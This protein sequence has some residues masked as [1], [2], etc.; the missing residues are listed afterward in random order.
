VGSTIIAGAAGG[1]GY[2]IHTVT[3]KEDVKVEATV[4]IDEDKLSDKIAKR[5]IEN[6]IKVASAEDAISKVRACKRNSD[7]E[8]YV[9]DHCKG[10]KF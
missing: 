6:E 4:K 9:R 7:N 1:V 5:L 3:H 2:T 8:Y 10:V